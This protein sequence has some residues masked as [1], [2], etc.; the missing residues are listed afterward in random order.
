MGQ[1]YKLCIL[2]SH[3]KNYPNSKKVE[4][5]LTSWE[6]NNG[7]KLCEFS[8]VGNHFVATLEELINKEHGKYAYYPIIVAGDYA[9][10]E[11]LTLNGENW[12]IY[13]LA[14]KFGKEI[15]PSEAPKPHHYRYIINEDKKVFFDCE[16]A[17]KQKIKFRDGC[18]EYWQMHPLTLLCSDGCNG[19]ESRGGGDYH[20]KHRMIGAWRRNV[21]VTSDNR[22]DEKEYREVYYKFYD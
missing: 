17:Y 20:H 10:A 18:I 9:D 13:D 22:P 3:K 5:Y 1:Y 14:E 11:P 8:W 15:K 6:Y 7:A 2:N 16:R 4:A 21:V 19:G 12:N